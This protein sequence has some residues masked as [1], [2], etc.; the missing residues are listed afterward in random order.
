MLKV[1]AYFIAIWVIVFVVILLMLA[2]S[3]AMNEIAETSA[4]EIALSGNSSDLPGIEG[5]VRSFPVWKWGLPI[6]LGIGAT[7][8]MLY[9]NREELKKR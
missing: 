8:I 4:N 1:V 5:A 2:V 9:E 3:P 6:L 7:G